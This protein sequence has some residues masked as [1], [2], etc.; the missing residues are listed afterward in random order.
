M[1]S[2]TTASLKNDRMYCGTLQNKQSPDVILEQ[3]LRPDVRD[4]R[5]NMRQNYL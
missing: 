3:N 4:V 2:C 1:P 5:F